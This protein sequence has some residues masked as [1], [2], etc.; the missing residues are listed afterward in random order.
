[1]ELKH[2]HSLAISEELLEVIRSFPVQRETEHCGVRMV[3]DPFAFYAECPRCGTRIKLRSFAAV[4]EIEDVFEA[5]F[6]WMNRPDAQ[7]VANQ[8]RIDLAS[9]S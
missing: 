3:V 6:E 2:H 7:E 9:E 5:V 1:V 8:R 4:P